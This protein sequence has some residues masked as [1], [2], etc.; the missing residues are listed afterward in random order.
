M[1]DD[2]IEEKEIKENKV[3]ILITEQEKDYLEIEVSYTGYADIGLYDIQGGKIG[4]IYS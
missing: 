4:G 2:G 1:E 3:A